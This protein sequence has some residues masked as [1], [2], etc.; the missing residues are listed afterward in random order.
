MSDGLKDYLAGKE[1]RLVD[2]AV[3][4]E[5][6]RMMRE[7]VIPQIVADQKAARRAAHFARLGI[8]DPLEGTT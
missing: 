3:L 7:E 5:Y 6:D 1:T 4:A 8:P 2:P